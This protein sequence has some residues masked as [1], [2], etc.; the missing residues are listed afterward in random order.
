MMSK[1]QAVASI[2]DTVGAVIVA[3]G[4]AVSIAWMVVGTWR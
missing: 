2:A 4:F 3:V 1:W